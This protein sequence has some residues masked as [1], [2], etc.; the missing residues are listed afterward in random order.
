MLDGFISQCLSNHIV[1]FLNAKVN[2]NLNAMSDIK[3]MT[4]PTCQN[5]VIIQF[6]M[7]N[8]FCACF[9]SDLQLSMDC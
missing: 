2:F 5:I 1:H 3:Y 6:T 8:L 7:Y 4:N 9:H